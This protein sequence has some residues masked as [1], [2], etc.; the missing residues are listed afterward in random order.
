MNIS[1]IL[2]YN[3][4]EL[5]NMLKIVK[6]NEIYDAIFVQI[7]P[8]AKK[9]I[10][11]ATADIKDLHIKEGRKIIPFLDILA[12]KIKAGILVRLVHSK[13]PGPQFRKDFDRNPVLIDGLERML[14]PRNHMK[15]V[16]VD[17][18]IAFMGSAN[19]TGAGMGMKSQNRRNFE[20]GIITDDKK[21]VNELSVIFDE[22]W[23]GSHCKNCGR[24][25]FC[26]DGISEIKY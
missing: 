14:C 24:K 2:C 16:I 7:I 22:L 11:V 19:L 18:H 6:H 13:E 26:A 23:M 4:L 1:I 5:I 10:W 12:D 20:T 3:R 9:Y 8:S 15:L 17:G 25:E 21:Y